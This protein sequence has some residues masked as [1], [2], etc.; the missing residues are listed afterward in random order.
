VQAPP[1]TGFEEVTNGEDAP[2]AAQGAV[3]DAH[4]VVDHRSDLGRHLVQVLRADVARV[5]RGAVV[6]LCQHEVLLTQHDVEL[7]AKDLRV[8]QVLHPQPH[9]RRLVRVRGTD[10]SLRR[11]ERVLAEEAFREPVEFLVVRHDQ[12]RVARH[13]QA[14]HV[15][16]LGLQGFEFG[17]Q[18]RRVDDDAVSDDGRDVR[19]E[20]ARGHELEG[21]RLALHDDP[22]PGV[23]TALVANDHI[24]VASQEI[25]QF[26]FAFV[27]PLGS[28]YDGCGHW[29]PSSWPRCTSSLTQPNNARRRTSG[30]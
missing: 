19:V 14:R 1:A 2:A 25:G 8:E 24:H 30:R 5:H 27:T 12:V 10:A 6:D 17:Q 29:T 18:H 23:V 20:H 4:G 26:T 11:A 16:A 7:L 28:D 22:V 21:E 13:D 9:S 3:H 15:D